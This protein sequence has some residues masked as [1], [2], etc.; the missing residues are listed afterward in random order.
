MRSSEWLSKSIFFLASGLYFLAVVLRSWLFYQGSPVLGKAMALLLIWALF[1]ASEW[2]I[3]HRWPHILPVFFPIYL[4]AQTF[5]TFLLLAL[6]ETPD[7]MGTLL[8]ILSMQAMLRLPTRI[9]A[10]WIAI[11]TALMF[12][13]F[14]NETG[15][16][17]IALTLIYTVGCVFLGSYMRNIRRAQA[18]RQRNQELAIELTQ[19]NQRLQ[20]SAAQAEQLAAAR[21]RNHLARDLHDS[22]TQT[23]FSMNLTTQSAA[24]LLERDPTR[25]DEQL[26]RLYDLTRSALSEM[27]LL[28]DRLKPEITE[29]SGLLPA[30]DQLLAQ[31]RFLGKLSVSI[32]A[33]GSGPLSSAEEENL[34]KIA[35][36][37][38]NNILKHAQAT[39][40]QIHL[41][42]DAPYWMAIEDQGRGFDIEQVQQP[43]KVG[44]S[45]M[46]ERAAE[47]GWQLEVITAPGAG[48]RIRVEKDISSTSHR[49]Q[50]A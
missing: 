14:W 38:L 40:A 3:S 2:L 42:L 44:L 9:G 43:G 25:V 31:G 18:A 35:Q 21:E 27:Q 26:N 37:A 17:A 4:I 39:Q 20:K 28:I 10:A 48:T 45:S 41:H 34:L 8:P 33:Q 29:P 49:S 32:K 11:C 15:S 36:E 16:E 7:F 46:R 13:L 47:I 12:W 5:L 30:L 6:P 24:L 22:V 50:E 19:A 23:A 1:F